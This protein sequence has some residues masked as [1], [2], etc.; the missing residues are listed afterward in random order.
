VFLEPRL[1]GETALLAAG[2]PGVRVFANDELG[3][4]PL[5]VPADG[6]TRLVALAIAEMTRATVSAVERGAGCP[7]EVTA[8]SVVGSVG[9]GWAGIGLRR[10]E[11]T[12]SSAGSG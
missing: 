10:A 1:T 2:F 5:A 7:D 8:E 3:R 6:G 11:G 4:G 12:G 9:V